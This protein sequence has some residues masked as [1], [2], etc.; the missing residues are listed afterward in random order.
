[1]VLITA[2]CAFEK[3]NVNTEPAEKESSPKVYDTS[4]KTQEKE[5]TGIPEE[6]Y[7]YYSEDVPS[8]IRDMMWGVTISERSII[9]FDDLSYLS[10]TYYGYDN[11]YHVG[12]MVVDKRL[13]NEVIEIFE[14]LCINKFP[15]EKMQLP[16]EFGGVDEVSMTANNTSAFNDRPLDDYGSLSYHQLGQAIDINPLYNPYINFTN[17]DIQPKAGEVYLDRNREDVGMIK[18]DSFCVQLFKKYGWEWGGD[19]SGLKDYQHFEKS[20]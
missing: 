4:A 17:N 20:I 19:W 9:N 10:M 16:C 18:N 3:N 7:I 11:A 12:H 5:Y 8:A 6:K 1:M 15:I 2:S 13:A 14:Q